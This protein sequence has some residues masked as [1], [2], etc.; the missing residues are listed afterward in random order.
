M[1]RAG[2]GHERIFVA[3]NAV[4]CYECSCSSDMSVGSARSGD[5]GRFGHIGHHIG[6]LG[7]GVGGDGSS[8]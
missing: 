2:V 1:Q 7:G 8:G 4:C 5:G 3:W 6:V